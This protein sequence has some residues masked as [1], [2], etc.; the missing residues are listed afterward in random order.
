MHF[1]RALLSVRNALAGVIIGAA[2]VAMAGGPRPAAPEPEDNQVNRGSAA[3]ARVLAE[4]AAMP[5][6]QRI[7]SLRARVETG[8]SAVLLLFLARE[9]VRRAR[10]EAQVENDAASEHSLGEA[11][12]YGL[13]S[14]VAMRTAAP[15]C[16]DTSSPDEYLREVGITLGPLLTWLSEQDEADRQAVTGA[17]LALDQRTNVPGRTDPLLCRR[18][19]HG[20]R[21]CPP[22]S[23]AKLCPENS[24]A[25]SE[26]SMSETLLAHQRRMRD[27]ARREVAALAR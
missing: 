9:E 3:H 8:E 20:D 19:E 11:A 1:R 13:A 6:E 27:K 7:A 4:L 26:F 16:T 21:F 14:Y 10:L 24:A 15:I 17:A 12:V 2:T 25:T 18:G 22:G 23:N 5:M